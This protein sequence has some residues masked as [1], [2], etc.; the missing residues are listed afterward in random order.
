MP[1]CW[2]LA[3]LFVILIVIATAVVV[4]LE[5]LALHKKDD[6]KNI[7]ALEVCEKDSA[8]NNGGASI[9]NGASCS[10]ICINGFTGTTCNDKSTVGCTTVSFTSGSTSYD[11]V[12]IGAA[13]PQLI[14]QGQA[15]YGIPLSF[16]PI[17]SK[18]SSADLSCDAENAIVSFNPGS[19]SLPEKT[20]PTAP[21]FTGP[22]SIVSGTGN[23]RRRRADAADA[24]LAPRTEES[25]SSS[26]HSTSSATP[27]KSHA[28]ST[29][30][31]SATPT[32]PAVNFIV[33]DDTLDFARVAV[34]YV[35]QTR[36]L[37]DAA[38]AQTKITSFLVSGGVSGYNS[39]GNVTVGQGVSVDFLSFSVDTGMGVL[40]G[41]ADG[42]V[43]IG[44][45]NGANDKRGAG[46]DIMI[47]AFGSSDSR[48]KRRASGRLTGEWNTEGRGGG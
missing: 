45:G 11:N 18:F 38:T 6:N 3:L 15:N 17:L 27:T 39:A 35:L 12:T 47:G 20:S 28:S 37:D 26:H 19:T 7:S 33:T 23:T 42:G 32:S 36:T 43:R 48:E 9:L 1:L 8:C 13:I 46:M 2:F 22:T 25:S 30:G 44:T 29:A 4:P 14:D 16:A 40:G 34:M 41:R 10:C 5:L 24:R 21:A 31:A